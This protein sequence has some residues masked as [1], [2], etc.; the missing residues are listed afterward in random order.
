MT[1]AATTS[2]TRNDYQ[3]NGS[4]TAYAFTFQVLNESNQISGKQFTLKVVLTDV[5]GAEVEQIEDTDYTVQ[6]DSPTRLGNITFATAPLATDRITFLSDIPNTQ[7]TD[8]INIG[9][10]KFPADSHEGTVDKLTLVAREIEERIDRSILL[11]ESSN[12]TNITIPVNAENA[13]KVVTI[14]TT[15]DDLDARELADVGVIPVSSFAA[16]LLEDETD[17]EARETLGLAPTDNFNIN[18]ITANDITVNG[19][20]TS[21]EGVGL[22]GDPITIANNA[23]DTAHDIDISAGLMKFDDNTGQ[24][25][26]A[27]LT[28]QIDNSWVAGNAQGGMDTGA[29]AANTWYYVYAIYNPTTKATDALFTATYDSPTMPSGFTKKRYRGAVRTDGSANIRNGSFTYNP[30]GSYKFRYKAGAI[31]DFNSTNLTSETT[32][33][34]SAPLNTVALISNGW[35]GTTIGAHLLRVYQ[36]DEDNLTVGTTNATFATGTSMTNYSVDMIKVDGLSQIKARSS[37][38]GGTIYINTTGWIDNLL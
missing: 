12:L 1:V 3:G 15:G 4:Q 24:V 22:F 27:A 30:D 29:V 36:T 17:A 11:S 18:D 32:I 21:S 19:A 5:N 25:I 31:A 10:D 13:N 34:L 8:Y 37:K 26:T 7:G 35:S 16:Q 14:N 23:T 38:T 2:A 28:K 9:T 6:Y 33:T 20:F